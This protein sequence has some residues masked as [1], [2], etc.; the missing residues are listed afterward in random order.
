MTEQE[1]FEQGWKTLHAKTTLR[2]YYR[3]NALWVKFY[4]VLLVAVCLSSFVGLTLYGILAQNFN[5]SVIAVGAAAVM[6][7][8]FLWFRM[9]DHIDR[10]EAVERMLGVKREIRKVFRGAIITGGHLPNCHP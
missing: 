8:F 3:N 7:G 4:A 1:S 6:V 5:R 2:T 10:V 9:S